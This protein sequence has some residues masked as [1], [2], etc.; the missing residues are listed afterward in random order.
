[1]I[2]YSKFTGWVY[3]LLCASLFILAISLVLVSLFFENP[4]TSTIIIII[5]SLIPILFFLI[6]IVWGELRT[7]AVKVTIEADKIKAKGFAG[8]GSE[9]TFLFS[10]ISGF[11]TSILPSQYRDYEYLYLISNNHKVVKISEFYHKNYNELK[12]QAESKFKDLGSEEFRL[13]K[14]INE[15][16]K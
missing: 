7:K 3:F 12:A 16:F 15:I 8:F 4:S 13:R 10:E 1:M 6:W 14:E 5:I 9:K 11:M 2:V